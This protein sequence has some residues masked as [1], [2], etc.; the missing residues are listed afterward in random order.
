MKVSNIILAQLLA[1]MTSKLIIVSH[2]VCIYAKRGKRQ[3]LENNIVEVLRNIECSSCLQEHED[4]FEQPNVQI[5][6]HIPFLVT[7]KMF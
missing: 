6:N 2:C 1:R 5:K 3:V 7:S 4:L